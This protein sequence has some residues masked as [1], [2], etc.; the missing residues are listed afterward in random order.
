MSAEQLNTPS[1]EVVSLSRP[2]SREIL[3]NVVLA[4]VLEPIPEKPGCT[5]RSF[6]LSER[7]KLDYFLTAAVNIGWDFYDLAERIKENGYK[8]PKVIFDTA[9]NAQV[10]SFKNRNGS[11]MNFGIISPLIPVVTAQLVYGGNG[12]EALKKTVHVLKQTGR[13]DADWNIKFYKLAEEYSKSGWKTQEIEA[14]SVFDYFSRTERETTSQQIFQHEYIN[15]FPIIQKVYGIMKDNRK[16]GLMKSSILAY[17]EMLQEC[18]NKPSVAADYIA[19]AIYLMLSDFK[20]DI[21]IT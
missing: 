15:G 6:D 18:G 11:R 10:N 20:E 21:L 5:T 19:T 17:N 14:K 9:Y 16:K 1:S 3:R 7:A 12:M 13:E 8:Q 2:T 4:G